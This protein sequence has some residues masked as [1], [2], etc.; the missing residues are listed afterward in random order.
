MMEIHTIYLDAVC[1]CMHNMLWLEVMVVIQVQRIYLRHTG[2]VWLQTAKL[3]AYDGY[4][5]QNFGN[6]VSMH[7]GFALIGTYDQKGVGGAYM[8][9]NYASCESLWEGTVDKRILV[10]TN[11]NYLV[12]Y[13]WTQCVFAFNSSTDPT[14]EP[15]LAPAMNPTMDP[16]GNPTIEPTINPTANPIV[17][18]TIDPTIDRT[19]NPTVNP[20][21]APTINPTVHPTTES[22]KYP[23]HI[24]TT[25]T[26]RDHSI[27]TTWIEA[28]AT[29]ERAEGGIMITEST[30]QIIITAV[31][32]GGMVLVL[33]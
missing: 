18:L 12:A 19:A 4:F 11:K 16:T 10:N 25:D 32:I 15:T 6:S 26:T 27:S 7:N 21:I 2:G 24:T 9:V 31:I 14:I 30:L 28:I 23:K 3:S 17:H 5:V 33:I 1:R 29:K 8:F 13:R 20:T 22:T